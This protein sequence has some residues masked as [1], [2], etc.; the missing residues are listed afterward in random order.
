MIEQPSAAHVT[1]LALTRKLD[2]FQRARPI[3]VEMG[4][5]DDGTTLVEV[6]I[7][8]S[9]RNK[10]YVHLARVPHENPEQA[11]RAL[12][13]TTAGLPW[14]GGSIGERAYGNAHR[15]KWDCPA[16]DVYEALTR[17]FRDVAH[18]S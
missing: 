14:T 9:A 18:Y 6:F 1:Y 12:A 7:Y 11:F 16:E 4:E 5:C 3:A 17:Y 8:L 2:F 13:D 10:R 15:I